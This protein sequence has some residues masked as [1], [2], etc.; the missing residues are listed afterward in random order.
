MK[1]IEPK[2]FLIG[3]STLV[4]EGVKAYLKHIGAS[5]WSTDAP[6]DAETLVEVMGRLC[7]RSFSPKINPN[8]TK[9]RE[10]NSEYLSNI[11]KQKHGSV[12]EH[13]SV[14]FIFADVSRV[15]THEL[16]RHRAGT[17]MSQESL[18]Y[19]RLDQLKGWAPTV[20]RESEK[21]MEIFVETF[22]ELEK[23]QLQLADIFKL[24]DPGVSFHIK[25]TATSA[26]R[27]VAPIGLGTSIG[28]SANFR[29]LRWVLEMRTDPSAEEEIRLVFGKVGEMLMERY[30]NMF[31]DFTQEMVDGHPHFKSAVSKI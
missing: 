27:R 8:V 29:T 30:P 3:E 5:E 12:T 28:W 22:E 25:K 11:V 6:S 17:A 31:G 21:A 14:N 16:V 15:F 9:V 4:K 13:A 10:G 1:K 23:L 18:R 2:V 24:N 7:Y 20:I 26:M 19:V